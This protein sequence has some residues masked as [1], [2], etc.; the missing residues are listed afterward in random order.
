MGY[1]RMT[2]SS[3]LG[4]SQLPDAARRLLAQSGSSRSTSGGTGADKALR[5]GGTWNKLEKGVSLFP[6]PYSRSLANVKQR[7][8][9]SPLPHLQF[10]LALSQLDPAN[11]PSDKP[12][13]ASRKTFPP[14]QP[15][16]SS[17]R[18]PL[19][20]TTAP[21]VAA[22]NTWSGKGKSKADILNSWRKAQGNFHALPD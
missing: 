7:T 17:S 14:S 8:L 1:S 5:F 11:T 21:N 12:A 3:P 18:T 4:L 19:A 20:E 13:S 6:F 9:A 10:L 15:I 22:P 2:S 16:A